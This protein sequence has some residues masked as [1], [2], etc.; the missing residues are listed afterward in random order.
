MLHPYPQR[1][2]PAWLVPVRSTGPRPHVGPRLQGRPGM[3][4]LELGRSSLRRTSFRPDQVASIAQTLT[5]TQP[6]GS[7][8]SRTAP[9][10]MSVVT[11]EARLGQATHGNRQRGV[12][13]P[14]NRSCGQMVAFGHEGH[15]E[16]DPLPASQP[17]LQLDA[18]RQSAE[19]VVHPSGACRS[20]TRI[21]GLMPSFL[22][23]GVP[24]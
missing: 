4:A 8:T 24:E 18:L 16:V 11:P 12:P 14:A 9:S 19:R 6:T 10:L 3:S 21:P 20:A 22:G 1:G 23:S 7:A 17:V 15:D 13:R 5:S 2:G